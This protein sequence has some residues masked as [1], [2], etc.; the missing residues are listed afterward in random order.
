MF[1]AFNI[2][3]ICACVANHLNIEIHYVSLVVGGLIISGQI[4]GSGL[5]FEAIRDQL[6]RSSDEEE[7]APFE[8][9]PLDHKPSFIHLR[10]AR[11]FHPGG[12]A[13]PSNEGIV[14]RGRLDSVDGFW[15]GKL[16]PATQL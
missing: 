15:F 9:P 14:W 12:S 8:L 16:A 10:D 5:Y 13:V 11:V 3:I 1:N 2:L 7:E 4:I 6:E